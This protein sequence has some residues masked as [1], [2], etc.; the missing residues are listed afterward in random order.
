M[1]LRPT[2]VSAESAANRGARSSRAAAA[3]AAHRSTSWPPPVYGLSESNTTD[4]P[5]NVV[6]SAH[7][8]KHA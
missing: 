7:G 3:A 4:S 1:A 8:A 6:T 2:A 5:A